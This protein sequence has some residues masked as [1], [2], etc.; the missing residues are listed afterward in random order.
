MDLNLSRHTKLKVEA[1]AEELRLSIFDIMVGTI[2]QALIKKNLKKLFKI[3]EKNIHISQK[4]GD[5]IISIESEPDL[6]TEPDLIEAISSQLSQYLHTTLKHKITQR[7]LIYITKESGIPLMGSIY[8]GLIDR[9]T[10]LI[11]VRPLTGC[12]LNCPFCSVDEGPQSKT[13]LTDYIV[14]PSYLIEE[15]TKLIEY[16][17]VTDIEIHIDGQSEPTLYPHLAELIA[18]FAKNPRIAVISM[19]TN[20]VPLDAPYIQ[21][22]E[23]AGLN[24]INL[25]INSMNSK[26]AR[27]LAGSSTYEVAHIKQVAQDIARSSIQLLVSPLWIPGLNDN[28]LEEIIAF[29][30]KLNIRSK[31][32]ILGLQNFLKYKFGRKIPSVK[33]VNMKRFKDKLHEWEETFGIRPLLLTPADFGIHSAKSYPRA[34]ERGEKTE[35]EIILPG[36]L[37]SKFENRREMLG[38]AKNRLIQVMESKSQIGDRVFVKITNTEDNI[39]YA[40]EINK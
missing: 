28:D 34:F 26:N 15:T 20:G 14:D 19:Q 4:N 21:K 35:V 18:A 9:G 24:R 2:P 32:P 38:R 31:F 29:V 5:L 11:Q 39:Y 1:I 6:P 7:D 13:R 22:L 25:S 40:H 3:S 37:G 16:K 10:N 12:L 33:Q 36:R 27:Y 17:D 8:F 30:S 23:K